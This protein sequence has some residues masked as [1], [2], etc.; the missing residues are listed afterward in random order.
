MFLLAQKFTFKS[1]RETKKIRRRVRITIMYRIFPT[2]SFDR[3]QGSS[4]SRFNIVLSLNLYGNCLSFFQGVHAGNEL[5]NNSKFL[6]NTYTYIYIYDLT[7]SIRV[8]QGLAGSTR[9]QQGLSGSTRVQQDLPGFSRVYHGLPVFSRVYQGLAGSIRVYQG[10]AGST[11]VYQCLSGSTR[12]Q[13]G[14][15]GST[16]VQ[17]GLKGSNRVQQDL[18]W[19][20]TTICLSYAC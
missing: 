13:Q 19:K 11:R 10:L 2:I 14:L 1:I 12:I 5:Q 6:Y 16:R 17:Q 18:A 3:S 20:Q 9:V 7:K 8:Y 4:S 15:P